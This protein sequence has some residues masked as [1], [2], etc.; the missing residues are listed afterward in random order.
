KFQ[1]FLSELLAGDPEEFYVRQVEKSLETDSN[2][3]GLGFLTMINDYSAKLGWKFAK[4]NTESPT[5]TVT[6]MAQIIV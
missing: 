1:T 6:S 4:I 5:L 2:A 3:S